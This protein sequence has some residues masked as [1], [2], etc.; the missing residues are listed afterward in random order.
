LSG[1]GRFVLVTGDPPA[2]PRLLS[3]ALGNV[4]GPGYKVIDI[5]SGPRADREGAQACCRRTVGADNNRRR[6]ADARRFGNRDVA[7]FSS[8]I[9]TIFPIDRLRRSVKGYWMATGLRRREYS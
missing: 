4:A 2:D 8:L 5:R 7:I 3:L 1:D 9:S 6:R